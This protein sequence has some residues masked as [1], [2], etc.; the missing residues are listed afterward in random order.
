MAAL[1]GEAQIV[2]ELAIKGPENIG[3]RS[4]PVWP[5][6]TPSLEQDV[7]GTLR[8]GRWTISGAYRG[9]PSKESEFGAAFAEYCGARF[10]V[11]TCNGSHALVTAL[12]ALDIA[13]GM[14]LSSQG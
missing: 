9:Q 11:T 8:S 3:E 10:G 5:P 7:T 6:S 12:E 14:R 2:T 4:W 13:P 1:R